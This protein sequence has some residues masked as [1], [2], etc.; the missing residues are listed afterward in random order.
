[1][2]TYTLITP[3]G[4]QLLRID[5]DT[6]E[7][8]WEKITALVGEIPHGAILFREQDGTAILCDVWFSYGS[9][10]FNHEL[11]GILAK[12]YADVM[13]IKARHPS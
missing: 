6:L 5:A 4:E 8:A 12:H 1:M 10:I 2:N 11:D 7:Q 3:L 13:A 9:R